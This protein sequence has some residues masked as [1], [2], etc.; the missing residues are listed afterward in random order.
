MLRGKPS[1]KNYQDFIIRYEKTPGIGFLSGWRGKQGD[2]DLRGEPNPQ[3]WQKYI[4]NGCFYEYPLPPSQRYFRFANKDYL[5]TA[6]QND[7]IENQEQ[8]VIQLYSE[9]VQKFRLAGQGLSAGPQPK[10]QL[11]RQRLINYFDPLPFFYPP[12][13]QQ[14]T[15]CERFPF[16]L[17]NQR[18]MFMYHSWDSQNSWL[19][20]IASKNFLYMNRTQA[21]KLKI[22]D[23]SWVRLTSAKGELIVQVKL[24]AGV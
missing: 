13:E 4:D 7:W 8:I 19:R 3:Q 14:Q 24:M 16:N 10:R 18:P 20:Q 1:I 2:Q 9:P 6:K 15:D 5:E 11:D 12:L 22:D 21:G 23:E 17:I